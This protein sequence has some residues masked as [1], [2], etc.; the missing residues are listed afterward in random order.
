MMCIYDGRSSLQVVSAQGRDAKT[1]LGRQQPLDRGLVGYVAQH[2]EGALRF[3]SPQRQAHFIA[4]ID[5]RESIPVQSLLLRPLRSAGGLQGVV[6]LINR[7]GTDEGNFTAEDLNI[8]N[9]VADQLSDALANLW[10]R[11]AE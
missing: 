8:A 9:Y 2:E 7:L 4:E 1:M 3:V 11:S 6:Q 5:G 10:I